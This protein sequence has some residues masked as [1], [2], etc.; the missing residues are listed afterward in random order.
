MP[1]IQ[2]VGVDLRSVLDERVGGP[3]GQQL[4]VDDDLGVADL[5]PG[6]PS[7]PLAGLK[8]RILVVDQLGPRGSTWML[9]GVA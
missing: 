1:E 4:G 2:R 7:G 8:S 3:T 9:S 6:D 5:L